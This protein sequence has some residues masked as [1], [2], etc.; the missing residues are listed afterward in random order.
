MTKEEKQFLLL[1]LKAIESLH[2]RNL[3]LETILERFPPRE[4]DWKGTAQELTEDQ[5]VQP[6]VQGIFRQILADIELD[7]PLDSESALVEF[8]RRA[9]VRGKPN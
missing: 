5:R 7:R 1:T 6:Q 2:F 8:L 3:A 9:P 4:I